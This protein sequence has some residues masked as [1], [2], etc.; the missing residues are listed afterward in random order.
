MMQRQ[1]LPIKPQGSWKSHSVKLKFD[2][3]SQV[4]DGNLRQSCEHLLGLNSR[5]FIGLTGIL[6]GARADEAK[7][8]SK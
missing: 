6:P 3:R 2:L 7:A 1:V 4:D 5:H 8:F